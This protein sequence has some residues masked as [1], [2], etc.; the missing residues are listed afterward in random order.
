MARAPRAGHTRE[1]LRSGAIARRALARLPTYRE[2]RSIRNALRDLDDRTL[3]DLGFDRSEISSVAAEF[4]G[5]TEKTRTRAPRS[6][7]RVAE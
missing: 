2:A 3:R 4:A 7:G 6:S 5:L 1:R